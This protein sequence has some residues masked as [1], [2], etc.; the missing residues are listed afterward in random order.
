[1]P[2][3]W[4]GCWVSGRRSRFLRPILCRSDGSCCRL[5]PNVGR[6]S[7]VLPSPNP[8]QGGFTCAWG[9]MGRLDLSTHFSWSFLARSCSVYLYK[10]YRS[11]GQLQL[12]TKPD[13]YSFSRRTSETVKQVPSCL[14]S[15]S[16]VVFL[17]YRVALAL[18]PAGLA[19]R[20]AVCW[21]LSPAHPLFLSP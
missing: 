14:L 12:N 4:A 19:L 6:L 20:G 18:S 7:C 13:S 2:V 17:F 8:K 21:G 1:M 3:T 9:K 16:T 5:F 11:R 10:G 15:P